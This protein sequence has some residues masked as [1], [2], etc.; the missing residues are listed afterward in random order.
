MNHT[1][2]HGSGKQTFNSSHTLPHP[3]MSGVFIR[4]T[5]SLLRNQIWAFHFQGH[6]LSHCRSKMLAVT[7]LVDSNSGDDDESAQ[8]NSAQRTKRLLNRLAYERGLVFR[9]GTNWC[10]TIVF[11]CSIV[12]QNCQCYDQLWNYIEYLSWRGALKQSRG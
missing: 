6:N 2:I 9:S 11:H 10:Y 3:S 7:R 5:I 8:R 1:W 4:S 12:L